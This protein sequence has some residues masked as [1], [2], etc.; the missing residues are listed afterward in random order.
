M[1][2]VTTT[3]G[4]L[5]FSIIDDVSTEQSFTVGTDT[6]AL[7]LMAS[8]ANVR[9][10]TASGADTSQQ[11]LVANFKEVRTLP[12]LRGKTLWFEAVSGTPDVHVEEQLKQIP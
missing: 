3:L 8:G 9:I 11:I 2:T 7:V 5:R 12:D 1:A 6:E 4:P 10:K